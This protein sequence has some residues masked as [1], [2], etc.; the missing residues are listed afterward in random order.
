MK[1]Y[2]IKKTSDSGSRKGRSTS[3]ELKITGSNTTP[4]GSQKQRRVGGPDMRIKQTAPGLSIAR[5]AAPSEDTTRSRNPNTLP[6]LSIARTTGEPS[7]EDTRPRKKRK[8][9][10]GIG[11]AGTSIES[12]KN[13]TDQSIRIKSERQPEHLPPAPKRRSIF[14]YQMQRALQQNQPPR[15]GGTSS[16]GISI[17]NTTADNNEMGMEI[18]SSAPKPKYF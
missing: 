2:R 14:G 18:K 13:P 10:L 17:A 12:Q 9:A 5:T 1:H 3:T 15:S 8:S 6:G 7:S 4:L 16:S 11:I